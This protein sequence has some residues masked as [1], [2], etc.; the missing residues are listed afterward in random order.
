MRALDFKTRLLQRLQTSLEF[1][2]LFDASMMYLFVNQFERKFKDVFQISPSRFLI[3]YRIH[4]ACCDLL[5]T[6]RTITQIAQEHGPYDHS[7]FIRYFR[8]TMGMTPN[9]Y[10]HYE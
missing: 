2:R 8:D 7:H 4:R 9:Q 10:R 3:R 6:D 5:H 1:V